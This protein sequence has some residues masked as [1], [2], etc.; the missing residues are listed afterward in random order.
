MA[1]DRT[2]PAFCEL[3]DVMVDWL[4]AAKIDHEGEEEALAAVRAFVALRNGATARRLDGA[5]AAVHPPEAVTGARRDLRRAI[6][7]LA[8]AACLPSP[9]REQLAGVER[10]L[11]AGATEVGRAAA[12]LDPAREARVVLERARREGRKTSRYPEPGF[13]RQLALGCLLAQ[14]REMGRLSQGA[15]CDLAARSGVKVPKAS[16]ARLEAGVPWKGA[17]LDELVTLLGQ[18]PQ[19]FRERAVKAHDFAARLT[20]P[21]GVRSD[22][23]WFA[24]LVAVHGDTAARACVR[25]AAAAALA[26]PLNG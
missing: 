17:P 21:I 4:E 20:R 7:A 19:E 9:T 2:L 22:E 1:E 15:L 25:F 13:A 11:I 8:G 12:V 16:L 18:H 14:Y 6:L 10:A 5:C 3:L 26:A 24:E 23:R